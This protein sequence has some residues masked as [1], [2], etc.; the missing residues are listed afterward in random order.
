MGHA[1]ETSLLLDATLGPF[2]ADSV[3]VNG[4]KSRSRDEIC[5]IF[6]FSSIDCNCENEKPESCQRGRLMVHLTQP[7]APRG[8]HVASSTLA[9]HSMLT[10]RLQCVEAP[11]SQ[12]GDDSRFVQ[13]TT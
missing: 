6:F 11:Q 5:D 12:I 1:D 9:S 13:H 3:L 4:S 10:E 2:T 7:V 8:T